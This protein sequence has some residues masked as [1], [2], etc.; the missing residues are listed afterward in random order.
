MSR[1]PAM[2]RFTENSALGKRISC[3][4]VAG[5]T[6]QDAIA[7]I[8]AVNQLGM[9]ATLDPL[10]ENVH[11]GAAA[12]RAAATAC[13]ILDTIHQRRVDSTVSVKLTQFGLDLGLEPARAQLRRVLE[14][15]RQ[16]NTFIR[17]D[18]EG[19]DYTEA[20]VA[21][22]EQLRGEGF[23]VGT[24]LQAY[25]HRTPTDLDRLLAQD[26]GIRLVKG[27]YKEPA[28]I[29]WQDKSEVDARYVD[30][31]RTLLDHGGYHAI[32]T[33]DERMIQAAIAHARQCGRAPE[34]FEFQMLYGIRRDLQRKL[35][36]EGWQVRVYIPF[37]PEWYP[38][39][40]RRLAERP[41]NLLF[42]LKN[43]VK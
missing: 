23:H 7:A 9:T 20:T 10:G 28:S 31:M 16:W 30:L 4:F 32:A 11:S 14:C 8:A 27:A 39:F 13:T 5:L 26:V 18:M 36:T 2:R 21:M 33:H 1:N 17:V 15:A 35:R 3:R 40:M 34:S 6:L 41:A 19:S 38:Y 43:L 12:E 29:A 25:L 24:V 22:V 42:L 37:G